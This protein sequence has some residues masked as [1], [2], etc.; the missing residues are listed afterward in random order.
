MTDP[1]NIELAK[2][3]RPALAEPAGSAFLARHPSGRLRIQESIRAMFVC[4]EE[5]SAAEIAEHS[6]YQISTSQALTA[7]G[8]LRVCGF[9]VKIEGRG[10]GGRWITA[11]T[12]ASRSSK[13]EQSP[14]KGQ[15]A[16]SSPAAT[17]TDSPNAPHEL[18]ATSDSRQ[19]KTL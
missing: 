18:P 17:T 13:A 16:G 11:K 14:Y 9:C 8:M 15:V 19:P 7:L 6:R 10:A 4:N 12:F 2:S 3:P 1:V 5:L